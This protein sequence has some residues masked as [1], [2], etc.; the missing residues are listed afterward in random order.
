MKTCRA[1]NRKEWRLWLRKNHN[2][3]NKVSL[4]VNKKHTLKP[5]M[6][7]R[8]AMEEAICFGWI[9]TTIKRLDEDK[10]IR[11]FSKRTN[12]SRW[13][14]NT[15]RYAKEL[16][17]KNKMTKSGLKAYKDGLKIPP[18][19]HSIPKNPPIPLD[20]KQAL[21]KNKKAKQNFYNFAP[22]YKRMYIIWVH[23]AKRQE[24]RIKR[25]KEVIERAKRNQKM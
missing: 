3:E 18:H 1:K 21:E 5:S 9:D 11:N 8:E 15:L 6:S 25:I 20:L 10:F 12:K 7:H 16:I 4:I 22:S 14:N 2:K 13:S 23:T 24:T 19:D 17:K